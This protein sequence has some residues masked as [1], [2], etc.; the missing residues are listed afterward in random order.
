MSGA[1]ARQAMGLAEGAGI[2]LMAS[3][4][5][6]TPAAVAAFF[7]VL[8]RM[9]A[10][11]HR[12]LR[13]DEAVELPGCPVCRVVL[14]R[15]EQALDSI[16]YEFVNDPAWRDQAA[17]A[18]GFCNLHAQQW[19]EQAHP[20]ST[21]L[22]Y[23]TVLGRIRQ[24]LER[25]RPS[26]A[27]MTGRLRASLAS[28]AE[29]R[30]GPLVESGICPFCT[31]REN[32]TGLAIGQLLDELR[33]STLSSR[34]AASDGLCVTHLNEA[35]AQGPGE[36]VLE[37]LRTRAEETHRILQA[38]LQEIIRKHDYRFRDEVFGA[39]LGSVQRAVHQVAGL[40]GVGDRRGRRGSIR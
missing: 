3:T 17:S 38:Q 15:V 7:L 40:P 8:E 33:S 37:A 11:Q 19:L 28:G 30:S 20:L 12:N 27:G 23:E 35:L 22:V 21:A 32:E 29:S 31:V 24:S 6:D 25:Q 5:R 13:L 26:R 36:T 34:Y 2:R 4:M 18:W 14:Q 1:F 9:M 16:N 39:E 10:Q